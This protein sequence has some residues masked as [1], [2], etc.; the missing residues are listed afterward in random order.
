MERVGKCVGVRG[1]VR[2]GEGK[3]EGRSRGCGEAWREVWKSALG[4]KGSV[5]IGV[6]KYVGMWGRWGRVC[7]V[8]VGKCFG[9]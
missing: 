7:V 5:G 4:R 3:C 9:V 2:R 8:S 1:S 6:G